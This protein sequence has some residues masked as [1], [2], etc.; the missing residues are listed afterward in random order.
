MQSRVEKFAE[1]AL[2][3]FLLSV[4]SDLTTRVF[5]IFCSLRMLLGSFNVRVFRPFV[6]ETT[7]VSN[8]GLF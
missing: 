7:E 4:Q 2:T 3:F 6:V 1:T 8:P 5:E